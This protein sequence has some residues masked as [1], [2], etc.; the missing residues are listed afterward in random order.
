MYVSTADCLLDWMPSKCNFQIFALE[1][2][3]G[4]RER[5]FPPMWDCI[6][7]FGQLEKFIPIQ[8]KKKKEERSF[9]SSMLLK[10]LDVLESCPWC[11][12]RS[13]EILNTFTKFGDCVWY[14]LM[15]FTHKPEIDEVFFLIQLHL[16]KACVLHFL[17]TDL[18]SC[19][20]FKLIEK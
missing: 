16:Q 2:W 6:L 18:K 17:F 12:C 5:A 20:I 4:K 7:I 8:K 1:K 11:P 19:R 10:D 14:L 9:L 13:L 15:C 3:G